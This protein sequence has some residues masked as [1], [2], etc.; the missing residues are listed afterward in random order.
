M[1][2]DRIKVGQ[3]ER[4][5]AFHAVELGCNIALL[6]EPG[7]HV[8]PS[9]RRTRP[10][11]GGYTVPV[12]ALSTARGGVVSTRAGLMDRVRSALGPPNTERPLGVADFARLQHL[13]RISMPY[14]YSL[15]GYVLYA[16]HEHFQPGRAGRGGSSVTIH[17]ALTCGVASTARSS[18]SGRCGAR[19]QAG[20]RS[21]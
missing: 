1:L 12:L 20:P 16:D 7:V 6:S 10:G 4:V 18:R 8:L 2:E 15:S 5:D 17:A 13:T 19:S 21:S 3:V 9:E 14:A 11:W